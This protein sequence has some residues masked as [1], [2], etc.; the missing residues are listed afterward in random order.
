MGDKLCFWLIP[1]HETRDWFVE[2][3]NRLAE[4]FGAPAFEPH[5]TVFVGPVDAVASP[6][7]VLGETAFEFDAITLRATG[8][9]QSPQF[10][11][12]LFVEFHQEQGLLDLEAKLRDRVPSDYVLRPHLSLLYHPLS[13]EERAHLAAEIELPFTEVRFEI[14][15]AVKCP[16]INETAED[17]RSWQILEE[18]RL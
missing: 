17:V 8:I 16:A 7:S 1:T 11:K 18:W 14:I 3:I 2:Q 9:G 4:R 12:T 5:L 6:A 13:E 15:Q 10:T